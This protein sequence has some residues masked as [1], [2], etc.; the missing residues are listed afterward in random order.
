MYRPLK[1]NE[2]KLCLEKIGRFI[3]GQEIDLAEQKLQAALLCQFH[4]SD[5]FISCD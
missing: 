1:K 2:K 3:K 5:S 4:Q